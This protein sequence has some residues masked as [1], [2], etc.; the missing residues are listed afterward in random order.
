M[1]VPPEK[2][3]VGGATSEWRGAWRGGGSAGGPVAKTLKKGVSWGS[4]NP[5]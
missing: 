2:G 4:Q 3:E 5:F 1:P